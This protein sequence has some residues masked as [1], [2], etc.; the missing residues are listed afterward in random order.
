MM[1]RTARLAV[2]VLLLG[3]GACAPAERAA[4]GGCWTTSTP[5]QLAERPSPLDSTMVTL[6]DAQAK[7][8]FGRP[9]ARERQVMGGLVQ[10]GEAWRLGAN[11]ATGIHLP[12]PAEIGGVAVQPGSYSLYAVP[13]TAQWTVVVNGNAERWGIPVDDAVTAEDVGSFTVVPEA[14]D[15]P[16]ETL[17]LTFQETGPE[18]ADLVVEWELTRVRIPVRRVAEG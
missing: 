6:G 17:T 16:V 12:F 7:V 15:A 10:Y 2:P 4:E 14:L 1:R 13:D 11:E 5:E 8:C 9:S 18:A 3:L